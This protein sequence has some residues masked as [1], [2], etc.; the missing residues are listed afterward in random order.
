MRVSPLSGIFYLG[1]RMNEQE[2]LL[3]TAAQLRARLEKI[4]D[5]IDEQIARVDRCIATAEDLSINT[6]TALARD[7]QKALDVKTEIILH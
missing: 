6:L 4:R 5:G 2:D 1:I 7:F 3:V